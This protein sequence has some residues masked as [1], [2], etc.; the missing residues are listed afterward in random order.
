MDPLAD[1]APDAV[2]TIRLERTLAVLRT[3]FRPDV[4]PSAP[5]APPEVLAA[6]VADA[7]RRRIETELDDERRIALAKR[8]LA[9][10]E[11]DDGVPSSL[12]RLVAFTG[13]DAGTV[14]RQM[15]GGDGA[16]GGAG[17][18]ACAE[19]PSLAA[20]LR[21]ELATADRVDLLCGFVRRDGL[22]LLDDSLNDVRRR[23][24]PFRVITT[25]SAIERAAID[26][27]VRYFNAEVGIGYD[28]E[29]A[30]PRAKAWLFHRNTGDDTAFVGSANLCRAALAEGMEWTLRLSGTATPELLRKFQDAFESHWTSGVFVPYD[31]AR[32]AS[33]LDAALAR[34]GAPPAIG[35]A[36]VDVRPLPHQQEALAALD[37]ERDT[38][39]RHR[40][41]VVAASGK[42][43]LAALDYR[44]L[45]DR[46]DASLLY[47]APTDEA[48][49]T[50]VRTFR[51][52]LGDEKFGASH[53]AGKRPRRRHLFATID[54]LAEL[55]IEELPA[56]R[57][58]VVIVDGF[59]PAATQAY[60]RLLAH[61][62]PEELLALTAT[63]DD[64]MLH[65]FDGRSA[66]ELPLCDAVA[67][68]L[69]APVHYY[70]V[71]D[72]VDLSDVAWKLGAYDADVLDARYT[73]NDARADVVVAALRERVTDVDTMRA[74]GWCVSDAH[75][76]YMA[77]VA[78]DAGIPAAGP[79][80]VA[81]LR[82]GEVRVLFTAR[83]DVDVP[84]VDVVLL[85]SPT[86]NPARFLR[87]LGVGLRRAPGKAALTVLDFIGTQRP[88]FRFD[89]RYRALTGTSRRALR[90]QV[91]Q[92]FPALPSGSRAVLDDEARRIVLANLG[93]PSR[94]SRGQ[95]AAE[96][97]SHGDLPL[98][99]Y[100]HEA[101]REL[102]DVY[103]NGGT[104][105][106]ARRAAGFATSSGG[107]D[108]ELLFRRV[109][110]FAHVDDAERAE[111]YRRLV[112]VD[113]PRYG[114]LSEREQ[115]LARMLLFAVW[116]KRGGFAS[117]PA[118]LA[119]LRR[120]RAVCAEIAELIDVAV[121]RARHVPIP[122][123]GELAS[124]PLVSHACYLR[125]EI[126]AALGYATLRRPPGGHTTGVAWCP[127]SRTDALFVTQGAGE[128]A[129]T[130]LFRWRP[131]H[132]LS[133]SSATGQRYLRHREQGSEVVLFLR[134]TSIGDGPAPFRCLGRVSYVEH[135]AE[136]VS[137][138][139]RLHRPMPSELVN[140]W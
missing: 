60:A 10:L 64:E 61:L 20:A 32:D 92:G 102:S 104:W 35:H 24:V 107:P 117:Y 7:V 6:H 31:P 25:A 134:E 86:D 53:V 113:G 97:R 126:L 37:V 28:A 38:H 94:L 30:R 83:D 124:V 66:Y 59:D 47:V 27:L 74:V 51:E 43:V 54:G 50:A 127:A 110:A 85:L 22:R 12:N 76:A 89:L 90:R 29:S 16:D 70:G 82:S 129:S 118:G 138:T 81:A 26:N 56:A 87:Q 71:A 1:G 109:A 68:E 41:L 57:F 67:A 15:R 23:G 101:D 65:H 139:W 137:I 80:G 128:P 135:D 2:R 69:L 77:R 121:N 52:A 72:G 132:R 114:E 95:L 115:R 106:S 84:E 100:L 36:G 75:A 33:R 131:R 34:G 73:G 19:S 42:T 130:E 98:A 58:D 112:D 13:F 91:E 9:L 120:H 79:D 123:D 96:V 39:D 46:R 17:G 93:A 122:L 103:R 78:C 108:E 21:A 116:P 63:P 18:A 8:V 45:R 125:E 14:P 119:H 111:V 48:R 133:T 88:E 55:G 49:D 99:S 4:E 5:V 105:T 62:R 11:T 140:G 136:P 3:R 44:R 40:N